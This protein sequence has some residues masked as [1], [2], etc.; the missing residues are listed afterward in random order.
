[1]RRLLESTLSGTTGEPARGR[2]ARRAG[3]APPTEEIAST[4]H[5]T[6]IAPPPTAPAGFKGGAWR[7]FKRRRR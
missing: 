3:T 2:A 6:A 4:P 7:G 1:M 5:E